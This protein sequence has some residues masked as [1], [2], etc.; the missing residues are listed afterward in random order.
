MFKKNTF[1]TFL[2]KKNKEKKQKETYMENAMEE[3]VWTL[4]T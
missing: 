3:F 1:P 2:G 4:D